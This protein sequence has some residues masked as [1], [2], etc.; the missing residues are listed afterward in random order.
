MTDRVPNPWGLAVGISLFTLA[1]AV[2]VY[3]EWRRRHPRTSSGPT[4]DQLIAR[5]R[6]EAV[7]ESAR[8]WKEPLTPE[9]APQLTVR[10]GPYVKDH[11]LN[12]SRIPRQRTTEMTVQI[13]AYPTQRDQRTTRENTKVGI[14]Q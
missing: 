14:S 2:G 6:E 3:V 11:I 1:C 7:T 13:P 5:I 12:G 4:V 10:V 8:R 9:A